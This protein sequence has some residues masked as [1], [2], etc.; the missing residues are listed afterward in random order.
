MA[1]D[2][3][4]FGRISRP[5]RC[6]APPGIRPHASAH[7]YFAVGPYHLWRRTRPRGRRWLRLIEHLGIWLQLWLWLWVR[8]IGLGRGRWSRIVGVWIR[9][10]WLRIRTVRIWFRLLGLRFF[11]LGFFGLRILRPELRPQFAGLR[12]IISDLRAKL[13]LPIRAVGQPGH[14]HRDRRGQHGQ[15]DRPV[16]GP[17]S[18]SALARDQSL[19]GELG[20]GLLQ[21]GVR[22]R[23]D[24]VR[25]LETVL[26]QRPPVGAD[27]VDQPRE[28]V[29]ELLLVIRFARSDRLIVELLEDLCVVL[30]QLV[31]TLRRDPDDHAP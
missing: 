19:A 14:E 10:V 6:W 29:V 30:Q 26:S 20:L 22:W 17:D 1:Q 21:R 4:R 5:H 7:R 16:R 9:L 25:R 18:P 12:S 11:R 2:E 3:G 13:E 23:K 8:I 31:L 27:E 28:R 24:H 15:R